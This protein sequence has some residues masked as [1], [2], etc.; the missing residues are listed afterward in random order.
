V[1]VDMGLII[2]K[3]GGSV[4]TD[5]LNEFTPNIENIYNI[6]REISDYLS[7]TKDDLIIVHGG[8]SYPHVVAKRHKLNEG[9]DTRKIIG[10]SLTARA[11][12]KIDDLI[13]EALIDYGVPAFPLQTSACFFVERNGEKKFFSSVLEA[14][15]KRKLVPV[16]Y[17]D[18][19][20]S[21]SHKMCTIFSGEMIIIE[22]LKLFKPDRVIFGTNVTGVYSENP[23]ENKDAELI[24]LIDDKNID[25][26][27]KRLKS[28]DKN[29]VTGGMY[30]KVDFCYRI[31]QM[32]IDC[33]IVD[34]RKKDN[35]YRILMGK[36]V[37]S[38]EV[39]YDKRDN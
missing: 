13:L 23:K 15:L 34:I 11:S 33:R 20:L 14:L 7:T 31:A 4:V 39:R 12:R 16:L 9:M 37:E 28:P 38:T 25:Y 36:E 8:G 32:G 2:L 6:A 26:I 5:K 21:D 29:D 27:L 1:K 10:I 30:H 22:L 18:V 24:K 35:L 17:G 19:V 3:I